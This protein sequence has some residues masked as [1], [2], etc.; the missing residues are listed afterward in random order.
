MEK[1]RH[2][3]NLTYSLSYE[4]FSKADIVIDAEFENVKIKNQVI[5]E[6][7]EVV[8]KHC[9]IATNTN[10]ITLGKISEGSCRPENVSCFFKY[11]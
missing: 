8:P 9:I 4:S 5:K 6:I 7:E 3:S 10:A 11:I 2:L 1:D